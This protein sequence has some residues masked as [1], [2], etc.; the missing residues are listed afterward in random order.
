MY[1]VEVFRGK[2]K[3]ALGVYPTESMALTVA[4]EWEKRWD[5]DRVIVLSI[6]NKG[7]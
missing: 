4:K 7:G 3:T 2:V 1:K 6:V 5:I